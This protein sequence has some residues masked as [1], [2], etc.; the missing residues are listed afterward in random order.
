MKTET[1]ENCEGTG[2]VE[3]RN[4]SNMSS[5]C[6]GGCYKDVTCEECNGSG[7][8]EIDSEEE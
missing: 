8:I 5:E 1:C 4:C 2:I 7:E 3:E 6:C